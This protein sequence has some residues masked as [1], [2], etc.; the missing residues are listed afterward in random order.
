MEKLKEIL[1]SEEF[2]SL[3]KKPFPGFVQP[4]LATLTDEYFDDPKWIFE[5]KLDGV[6]CLVTIND[7][8]VTLYS[9]NENIMNEAYPEIVAALESHHYPNVIVDG[10]IVAFEGKTTSFQKLQGR[11][12]LKD[13]ELIEKSKVKVFLYLFDIL[14]LESYDLTHLQ[15]KS[16]KKILKTAL[17][18][19]SPI[20]YTTHR[21]KNGI[22]LL[23]EACNKRWE[24]LIAKD[25]QA[26]YVH[27]RSKNWLK[28][29]CS[30]GQELVIGG[31]TEPQGGRIG[32]GALLVGYYEDGKLLFAGK[33]GTGFD[34]T[35]LRKWRKKFNKIEIEES[36]FKNQKIN[37]GGNYHWIK[38]EYVGQ[39]G[40]TEWTKT[41]KLRHPRFLGMRDDKEANQVVKES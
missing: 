32:F 19:S 4:M 5:R 21:N 34:D 18:W 17:W 15:L 30:K 14:H 39:F 40:F 28:F 35:F 20:R 9:R 27:S 38:P 22:E 2:K 10:E 33:V 29:K 25:S 24:G 31:F 37:Q 3:G 1:T 16:R 7:G 11:I 23:Q 26:K 13:K 12:Q 36:P 6:R 8:K 41:N